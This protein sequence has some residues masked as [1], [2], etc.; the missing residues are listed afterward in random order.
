MN[1]QTRHE[2]YRKLPLKYKEAGRKL[3]LKQLHDWAIKVDTRLQDMDYDMEVPEAVVR[4][5]QMQVNNGMLQAYVP[6]R[7][8]ELIKASATLHNC[9]RTYAKRV[10]ARQCDI[11]LMTD[12]KGLLRACLEIREGA[13]VQAKLKYNTPVRDDAE[14]NAAIVDWCGKT[15]LKIKTRDVDQAAQQDGEIRRIG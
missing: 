7:A 3:P 1:K 10:V 14:I 15:R 4:R 13:L 8:E 9:V 6:R 5:L 11:V 12:D 2:L